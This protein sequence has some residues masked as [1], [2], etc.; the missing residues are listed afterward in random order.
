MLSQNV[1]NIVYLIAAV[2]FILDL[3]ML[4]KAALGLPRLER[5]LEDQ[6]LPPVGGPLK[7]PQQVATARM[8]QR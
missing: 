5:H 2:L 3:K 7:A 1:V 4:A 6:S 8:G